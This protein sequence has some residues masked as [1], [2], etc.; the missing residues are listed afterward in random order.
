MQVFSLLARGLTNREVAGQLCVSEKSV[1]TYKTRLMGKLRA[2]TTPELTAL[3]H[4]WQ[5]SGRSALR[6]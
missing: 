1:H 3:F 5:E 4:A 6:P 2:R